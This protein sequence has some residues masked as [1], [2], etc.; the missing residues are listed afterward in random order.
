MSQSKF[1]E[2]TTG[3]E[4]GIQPVSLMLTLTLPVFPDGLCGPPAFAGVNSDPL[5]P[6]RDPISQLARG[7]R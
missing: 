3:F 2:G 5:K 4:L 7:A 6:I 1:I